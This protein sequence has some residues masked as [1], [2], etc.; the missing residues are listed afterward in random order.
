ML[1]I[2]EKLFLDCLRSLEML[3]L[4]YTLLDYTSKRM[5]YNLLALFGQKL[6]RL[7]S[8]LDSPTLKKKPSAW[9]IPIIKWD[10]KKELDHLGLDAYMY[11]RFLRFL[12]VYF[13]GLSLVAVPLI[14]FNFFAPNF[15]GLP[16]ENVLDEP[17]VLSSSATADNNST[18]SNAT[19]NPRL[20]W[21]TMQNLHPNSSWFYLY[22][23]AAFY[24]SF[25]AYYLMLR[26]WLEYIQLR[27]QWFATQAYRGD[28][29][30][31]ILMLTDIPVK[32]RSEVSIADFLEN[33]DPAIPQQVML[34]RHY[35]ELEPLIDEHD[36]YTR[37][38]ESVL[39]TCK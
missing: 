7:K 23:A 35:E 39:Y 1:I 3:L 16:W 36:R 4:V 9:L 8:L 6:R 25:L 12:S 17:G 5:V 26:M 32:E 20:D 28:R 38:M 21:L 18:Y 30:N 29:H 33:V 24:Y 2:Y 34:G 27:R 37:K 11:L 19:S 22:T 14:V 13:I 10:E 15:A 31:R